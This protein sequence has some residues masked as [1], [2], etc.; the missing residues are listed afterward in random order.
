MTIAGFVKTSLIE[1]PGKISSVIFVAGCNFRC[2][3][4]QNSHLVD[5][6]K[7]KKLKIYPEKIILKDLEK[8]R[9][10][11]DGVVVTGGEPTL[12]KD[13]I[14]FLEKI[15]KLGLQTM[16]E[17]NGSLPEVI[18]NLIFRQLIDYIAVDYKIPL[19]D[20]PKILKSPTPIVNLKS[21]FKLIFQSGIPFEVRTTLVPT[22]HSQEI[23]KKMGEEIKEIIGKRKSFIWYLQNFQSQNCLETKFGKIKPFTPVEMENFL[24]IVKKINPKAK[25]RK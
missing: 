14:C 10:F 7:I 21:C 4:C 12:Q 8:R 25:I 3:F 6:Q 23:L 13:L 16:I 2:P 22:I 24:K 1:W 20:Y 15:K 11:I 19:E 18:A 5:P 17:T 9:K